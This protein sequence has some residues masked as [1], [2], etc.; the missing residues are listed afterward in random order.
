M[1]TT[2]TV[3]AMVGSVPV[4][5]RI[6]LD[7]ALWY[8]IPI[9]FMAVYVAVFSKPATAV[10]PHFIAVALPLLLIL[11]ARLALSRFVSN[12]AFNRWVASCLISVP[13]TL[14]I[15]YYTLVLIGLASWGGVVS[16]D[17]IP[18]FLEQRQVAADLLHIPNPLIAWAPLL[19]F[20][21]LSRA[22]WLYLRHFDWTIGWTRT[23]SDWTVA[24][25]L[26]GGIAVAAIY[27]FDFS[28]GAGTRVAEPISLTLFPPR[29]V[30]ALEGYTANP[31]S[32]SRIDRTVEAAR[33]AYV[34][35][36]SAGRKNLIL[37]VVDA[38]R[39]DHM[40]VYGYGRDTTPNLARIS[41][42]LPARII[43]GT[44]ASC[45]D[46]ACAMFSLFS[47]KFPSEFSFHPFFLHEALRRNGY[48]IHLILSGDHT[49]FF[50][51][52][53]FYGDVDSFYD[54]NQAGDGLL[55]DDQQVL[56]QFA[57]M[58]N[59]D[60]KPVMFQ[61]HLMSAH[62][63][64]SYQTIP[65]PFLPAERY[66]LGASRDTGPG[67][68][69]T[70][71]AV[72]FYDNGVLKADSVINSL[73]AALQSKGYL[74]NSLIVITADHGEALGEHGL[75]KHANSVREELLRIPLILLFYGYHT[76]LPDRPRNYPSQVDLAPTILGELELP[77]PT[78]WVGQALQKPGH[79]EFSFFEEHAFAGL[80]D[81]RDP[82]HAWKYWNNRSSGEDHVF[83]LNTD[84]HENHDLRDVIPQDQL[85]ALRARLR[86]ET[87]SDLVVR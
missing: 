57:A 19:L 20:L 80:L 86:A 54:G 84:P 26:V 43:T 77:L 12:A 81:H 56:D 5:R 7:V 11:L 87:S 29:A 63:L 53:S 47:S 13:L 18:T 9:V 52:K 34:P 48:R 4:V 42:E 72:N 16:W 15:V 28:F 35:S 33:G 78:V 25:I 65:G 59:W 3:A 74:Q 32:A 8:C 66:G 21:A 62:I 2:C 31:I 1:A 30:L 49:H 36:N 83:E 10:I 68:V 38:L 14:L 70:Q 37:I 79:A 51:L 76:Q 50:G 69:P 60:G 39:P 24:T 82:I 64:R 55:N 67:G 6:A 44:H 45:G 85:T 27:V 46:T 61:F 17:V 40:G 23:V 41:K 75:F 73:I 58:P 22:S 71:S